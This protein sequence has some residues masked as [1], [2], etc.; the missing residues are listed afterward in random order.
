MRHTSGDPHQAYATAREPYKLKYPNARMHH[1]EPRSRN[2]PDREFNLFPWNERAHTAYHVLFP[3]MTIREVWAVIA[4]VHLVVFNSTDT[5]IVREW[6]L[7][8][9]FHV[10]PCERRYMASAQSVEDLRAAWATCFW[11]ADLVHAQRLLRYMTLFMVFGRH[12]DDSHEVFNSDSLRAMIQGLYRDEPERAWAF[13][14]C[15]QLMPQT[16][17]L[18]AVKRMIRSIRTR[19]NAFPIH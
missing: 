5:H 16:A 1:M 6:C 18:R 4:D 12:A 8:F 2:G 19:A 9:R 3:H 11:S 10:E 7:P 17:S 14:A 15:F 13:R